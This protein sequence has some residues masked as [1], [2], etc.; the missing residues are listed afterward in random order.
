MKL[1]SM[2][3]LAVASVSVLAC[4]R[5]DSHK[6]T[7]VM[8]EAIELNNAG[9]LTAAEKKMEEAIQIYRDN[10]VAHFN[11]GQILENRQR[12]DAEP[13][14][15]DDA[16]E[17]F[18]EAVRLKSGDAMY[19]YRLGK[20]YYQNA[21]LEKA[22]KH[23]EKALKI[24]GKLYKAHY[25]LGLVYKGQDKVKAAAQAWTNSAEAN[26]LFGKPFNALGNSLHSVGQTSGSCPCP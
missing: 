13:A 22:A 3:I 15:F 12:P 14:K 18:E 7:K 19:N 1:H 17:A 26:P 4:G 9:Q 25:F 20:A 23:L 21:K 11:L 24:N 10:H 6:S 5:P 16:V 8:K 2:L